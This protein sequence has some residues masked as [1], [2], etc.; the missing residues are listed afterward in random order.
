MAEPSV[1]PPLPEGLKTWPDEAKV[2]FL[3]L[4]A[5]KVGVNR[6]N[7][8]TA[9]MFDV[10]VSD[11]N[12]WRWLARPEVQEY[13]AWIQSELKADYKR[14]EY[15]QK[16]ERVATLAEVAKALYARFEAEDDKGPEASHSVLATLAKE[17]RATLSELHAQTDGEGLDDAKIVSLVETIEARHKKR[18]ESSERAEKL[19]GEVAN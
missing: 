12:M 2:Y 14:L 4:R 6:A 16:Y 13:V 11:S 17:I 18:I 8:L 1:K 5:R 19:L 9:K 3:N 15:A 10:G 7:R